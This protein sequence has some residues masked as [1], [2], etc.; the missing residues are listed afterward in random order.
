MTCCRGIFLLIH[1]AVAVHT[2][3]VYQSYSALLVVYFADLLYLGLES[4]NKE[5]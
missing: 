5:V 2:L 1:L 4:I 3:T